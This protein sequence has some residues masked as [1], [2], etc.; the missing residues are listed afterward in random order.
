MVVT[1][2]IEKVRPTLVLSKTDA[3]QK[4]RGAG[5][6]AFFSENLAATRSS[7]LTHA[8]LARVSSRLAWHGLLPIRNATQLRRRSDAFPR[9]ARELSLS[10]IDPRQAQH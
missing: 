1:M 5:I 10:A 7:S 2:Q 6:L 3:R 4:S 9:Q 8:G